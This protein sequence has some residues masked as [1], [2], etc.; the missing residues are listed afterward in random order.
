ML[1][2]QGL[3]TSYTATAV[4]VATVVSSAPFDI[5]ADASFTSSAMTATINTP[6]YWYPATEKLGTSG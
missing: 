1:C 6:R 3:S 5:V 4:I 2:H